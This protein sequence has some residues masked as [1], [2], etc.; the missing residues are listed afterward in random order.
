[1][2]RFSGPAA[3]CFLGLAPPE[4]WIA[5]H[6]NALV[7]PMAKE[8]RVKVAAALVVGLRLFNDNR[9]SPSPRIFADPGHLSAHTLP[10]HATSDSELSMCNFIGDVKLRCWGSDWR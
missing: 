6:H 5:S 7:L 1:M 2:T 3:L 9:V 10:R 4:V 8:F